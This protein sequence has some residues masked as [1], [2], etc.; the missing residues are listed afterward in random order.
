MWEKFK[1]KS[2][3]HQ[4]AIIAIE[5][6]ILYLII[7]N[8]DRIFGGIG[9]F[10]SVIS[11]FIMG[12]A[13]AYLLNRPASGI[14]LLLERSQSGWVV[15]KAQKLS[16]FLVFL[17]LIG[18]ISLVISFA[19]PIV[20]DN[21][22]DFGYNVTI[23]YNSFV[24]WVA[25]IDTNNFVYGLIPELSGN[26]LD[27]I[28]PELVNQLGTGAVA[29]AEHIMNIV[30]GIVNIFLAIITALYMLLSKENLMALVKRILKLFM[31]PVA[32][33]NVADYAHKSNK[34]FY[35]FV[36]AQFLDACVVGI[37]GTVILAFM[38]VPYAVTFGLMLGTFNMIPIF[39]SIFATL[40]TVVVTI[41]T[42]GIPLA[43][44]TFVA[45]IILQQVD[46]NVIG[47][48][49]TG[50][51]LGLKPLLIIFAIIV[52]GHYFGIIGMF[53]AVPVAAM[54]KMFLEDFM[55]ARERK[56]SK[57]KKSLDE[58]EGGKHGA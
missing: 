40:I 43:L 21:L 36:G 50:D 6:A 45:L 34:I 14:Q 1:E 15:K 29:F 30:S 17:L 52:G 51:A 5:L 41:F 54:L 55:D 20:V 58:K 37:A 57:L 38:G 11:P 22:L 24:D 16:V 35:K 23:Y 10:L 47:P 46:A 3:Y 2:L 42:G 9:N 49:I 25:A 8:I 33:Q 4:I 19:V 18:I 27:F 53:V 28:T 56:L 12:A 26:L 44:M 32:Y 13:I 7:V 39:G 31:R 48:K